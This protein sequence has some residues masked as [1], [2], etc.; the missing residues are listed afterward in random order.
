MRFRLQVL[1]SLFAVCGAFLLPSLVDAQSTYVWT[2]ATSGDWN[3]ASNWNPN[4]IPGGTAAQGGNPEDI[5]DFNSSSRTSVTVSQS[6]ELGAISFAYGPVYSFQL[7]AFL[8]LRH[9]V[10]NLSTTTQNSF[11]T[12]PG[13]L[14]FVQD[15]DAANS[16][17]TNNQ[18]LDFSGTSSAG[19]AQITNNAGGTVYFSNSASAA[20]AVIYNGGTVDYSYMTAPSTLGS[21][22]DGIASA[23]IFLGGQTLSIGSLNYTQTIDGSI[24][25]G[26]FEGGAG[27]SLTKV[28]TGFLQL[29]GACTYTGKTTVQQGLLEVD[30]TLASPETLVDTGATLAGAGHIG[31]LVAQ[32]GSYIIPGD[33]YNPSTSP[34]NTTLTA[35]RLLCAA[36]PTVETRIGNVG[37]A[38]HGDYLSLNSPLQSGFCPHLH[39]S[40]LSAGLPL[41]V[42]DYYLLVL[43]QGTTDYTAGNIDFDFSYFPSYR[44]ATGSIVVANLGSVSAIYLQL[45]S[46]GDEIFGN[47][48]D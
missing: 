5:A 17:I 18:D 40:L 26:G 37:S 30:G 45:T 15:G 39:F 3:T 47:G 38:T 46:L 4:G 33:I 6:V 12:G 13:T 41:T 29:T 43:I 44:Q 24:A 11:T 23:K 14:D 48:F 2:G 27:G 9:G 35:G 42:G 31:D 36:T 16:L 25:D 7:N 22:A 34:P 20:Q 21:I 32:A 28:G 8:Q 19:T 1:C 10:L